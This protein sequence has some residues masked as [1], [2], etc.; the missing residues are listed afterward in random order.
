MRA[1]PASD[2]Y[3]DGYVVDSPDEICYLK[4]RRPGD[5]AD[6]DE[7]AQLISPG[8]CQWR[9]QLWRSKTVVIQRKGPGV[10]RKPYLPV[11]L[12]QKNRC[13]TPVGGS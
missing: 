6:A 9:R 1:Y 2:R 4:V 10:P 12:P 7:P 13:P 11:A 8:S 5:G 3:A